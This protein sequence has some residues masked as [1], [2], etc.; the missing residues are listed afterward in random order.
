[1][2]SRLFHLS[3]VEQADGVYEEEPDSVAEA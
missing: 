3:A 2:L 1:M